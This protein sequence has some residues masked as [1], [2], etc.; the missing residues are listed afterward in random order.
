M[1]IVFAVAGVVCLIV[2]FTCC[3]CDEKQLYCMKRRRRHR[4]RN[5]RASSPPPRAPP[6]GSRENAHPIGSQE[7]AIPY[8][9]LPPQPPPYSDIVR[10]LPPAYENI[11]YES[12]DDARNQ[13]G[14]HVITSHNHVVNDVASAADEIVLSINTNMHTQTTETECSVAN[15]GPLNATPVTSHISH[16][17]NRKKKQENVTKIRKMSTEIQHV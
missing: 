13:G 4:E 16:N 14:S 12:C 15:S 10:D 6:I 17:M 7:T 8:I 9:Y 3:C 1:S 5:S 2:I 11:A